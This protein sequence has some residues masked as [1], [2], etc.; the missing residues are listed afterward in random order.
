[1]KKS[2][3]NIFRES[4]FGIIFLNILN[5]LFF[6]SAPG[7]YGVEPHPYL[8]LILLIATR[9][10][11][12]AGF[13]I[14]SLCSSVFCGICY[15]KAGN[16]V[17]HDPYITKT[18]VVFMVT[19]WI[20]GEIRQVYIRKMQKNQ[21][22]LKEQKYAVSLLEE[23]SKLL[24]KVNREMEK[25]IMD[26]VSTFS[27]LYETSQRL[28]SFN[29]E[30]I[31][32]AI[33]Q[34]LVQYLD[35]QVSSVYLVK[36]NKLVLKE[37]IGE[38]PNRA[39][40]IDYTKDNGLIA[41]A[42][43][44]R[45]IFSIRDFLFFNK[46]EMIDVNQSIMAAP[47]IKSNGELLG[48][49]AI[50]KM[51]F[52]KITASSLKI[53]S[54]LADWVSSDIENALYFQEVKNKNIIDEVLN[55]YTVNYFHTRL[56]QEFYRS[57]RYVLPLSVILLRVKNIENISVNKQLN[58]FK[59]ISTSLNTALRLTDIVTRYKDDIQFGMILT[60]TDNDQAKL[61][62]VRLKNVFQSL[63]INAINDG[64]PLE[65]EFAVGSFNSEFKDKD[66]LLI[67]T[68]AE[69]VKCTQEGSKLNVSL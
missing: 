29:E 55:I 9:Y 11:T 24:K 57:K 61:A 44:E 21:K 45:S 31:Y 26:E 6:H 17:F 38:K 10:G 32:S 48:V 35:A 16:Q 22:E 13:F 7:Y 63:G 60:M 51:P 69:F 30:D 53:F 66:Q 42:V 36:K 50:E 39:E 58:M 62:V 59:F 25:R 49:L 15:L 46:D 54:L 8:G 14:A 65:L 67:S 68:E 12:G 2:S 37:S 1:M 19:G 23:E 4:I 64:K 34:V 43:R 47:L 18:A 33:L 41:R 56:S 3:Y 27:S 5:Y 28:Q 40:N 52:F 20:I